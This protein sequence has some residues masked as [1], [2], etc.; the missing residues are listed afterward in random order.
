MC[1]F[2]D[3]GLAQGCTL[4][5]RSLC[6]ELKLHTSYLVWRFGHPVWQRL[7][8]SRVCGTGSVLT[9]SVLIKLFRKQVVAA[10]HTANGP[11]LLFGPEHPQSAGSQI[12]TCMQAN[13]NCILGTGQR[14]REREREKGNLVKST[15]TVCH[16]SLI[17]NNLLWT[18][19]SPSPFLSSISPN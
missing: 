11:Q 9:L 5:E 19:P 3:P 8:C 17:I 1:T 2:F 10:A 13:Q 14:K 12:S 15:Q 16:L 4:L 6:K 7:I 18:H